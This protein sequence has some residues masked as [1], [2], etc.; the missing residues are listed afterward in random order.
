MPYIDGAYIPE[1]ISAKSIQD[2]LKGKIDPQVLFV[3]M[4]MAEDLSAQREEI[5]AMAGA[6]DSLAQSVGMTASAA[7]AMKDK[8]DAMRGEHLDERTSPYVQATDPKE[9][10]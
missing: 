7:M 5:K 6:F 1:R 10:D 9:E 4:A 3:L 8:I 2:R